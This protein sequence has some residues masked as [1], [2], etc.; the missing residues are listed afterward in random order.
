MTGEAEMLMI[1][2]HLES[3]AD[4]AYLDA[5]DEAGTYQRLA[6]ELAKEAANDAQ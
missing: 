3:R 4:D 1:A 6:A 5:L 2:N